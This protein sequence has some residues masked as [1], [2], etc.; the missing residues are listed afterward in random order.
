M[1]AVIGKCANVTVHSGQ[2]DGFTINL[3]T[4]Q[5]AFIYF[6]EFGY[7][8]KFIHISCQVY[9]PHHLPWVSPGPQRP[10]CDAGREA[11]ERHILCGPGEWRYPVPPERR[12]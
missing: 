4:Q 8:Y 3:Y 2:A 6:I 11:T 10:G 5:F 1:C 12:L 9:P 7:F